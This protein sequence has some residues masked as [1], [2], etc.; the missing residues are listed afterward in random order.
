M[1]GKGRITRRGF[2][3]T[4]IGG[5]VTAG[6]AGVVGRARAQE[7]EEKKTD[8]I[9]R[10]LGKTDISLPIVSMGVMNSNNPEVVEASYK[11][12]V[13]HFDTAAYYQSGNNERMVGEVIK[14]LG[15][16]DDVIIAT[17]IYTPD[18]RK[19]DTPESTRKKMLWQIDE[20]LGRLQM[21]HVDLLYVHNIQDPDEVRN[22]AIYTTMR[23]IK[24]S[25][26][27]RYVGITTHTRMAEIIEAAVEKGWCDVILTVVNFTL[28]DYKELFTAV[29]RAA[30]KGIGLVAMK[31]QAG[32]HRRSKLEISD[33]ISSSTVA[34][35]SLKWALRNEKFTTAIPGYTTFEHMK[36]DFSVAGSLEYTEQEKK[37]LSDC[38]VKL[39]MGFCRQCGMCLAT[40]R[41]G[42]D[43]PCLM[44]THMYAA[45][46]TNFHH[47]RQ[48]LGEADPGRGLEA[49]ASCGRCSARCVH[50]VDIAGAVEDLKLIYG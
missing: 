26:K 41:G 50:R 11:I 25:G 30:G 37:F 15:V 40:C 6:L 20:C 7:A 35:A 9:Y 49:C 10:K 14:K 29:D 8:I 32:S 12:G 18:M 5:V 45:R 4:A 38:D 34:T 31:T 27:A 13:K 43:I 42:A 23:E 17:K 33:E 48:T 22:E 46:Y 47:A 3:S 28:A 21:D 2:M 16:R 44:R 39:S 1:E 24:K 36:E 19:G